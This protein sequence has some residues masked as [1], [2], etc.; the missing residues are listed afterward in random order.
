M[1]TEDRFDAI[2]FLT[3]D[4][5]L[6]ELLRDLGPSAWLWVKAQIWQESRFNPMAVS[7]AGAAGLMQ[8][9]PGTDRDV[10]GD[11]D[12]F[13]PAGNIDNGVR[14]LAEQYRKFPEIPDPR[15]R[16]C[17]ALAAYN[18]G[19]QYLNRALELAREAEGLPGSLGG[20]RA[21]GSPAGAFQLWPVGLD[22]LAADDCTV[23]GLHAEF[24]QVADYVEKI[25][26]RFNFYAAEVL[27]A[28]E[29]V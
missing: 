2:I 27:A 14:Y 4:Q 19:R 10:D 1:K 18:C 21:L 26:G 15:Q 22:F 13:D 9:M 23:E 5:H 20:W 11:L 17:F 28:G 29:V 25:S 3:V 6:P 12:R 8:L 16:I 7:E 24:R